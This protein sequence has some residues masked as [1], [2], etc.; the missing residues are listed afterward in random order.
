VHHMI[1]KFNGGETTLTEIRAPVEQELQ[2]HMK[3]HPELLPAD[4]L[5]YE[6]DVLVIGRETALPSG[7][8]DLLAIAE[9]GELLVIEMKRGPENSDF[10]RALAQLVDYGSDLWRLPLD[11]LEHEIVVPYLASK[12][13][14]G[15]AKGAKSLDEAIGLAW[16][17]AGVEPRDVR[18]NLKAT[19]KRGDFTYL[20]AAQTL[21]PNMERAIE[22]LN[23]TSTARFF[24]IEL[25]KFKSEDGGV[26][27]YEGRLRV[28][29]KAATAPSSGIERQEDLIGT[30]AIGQRELV[31]NIFEVADRLRMTVFVGAVGASLKVVVPEL[32]SPVSV[33]WVY[34]DGH[35][36]YGGSRQL[37]LGYSKPQFAKLTSSSERLGAWRA[38]VDGMVGA[39]P[40]EGA[41]VT[42]AILPWG[43]VPANLD[44]TVAALEAL[45]GDDEPSDAPA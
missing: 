15:P 7:R 18:A 4:E 40:I 3:D 10:R 41:A 16:P 22:Y 25:V 31:R 37:T 42:G 44:A 13:C 5:G 43:T 21:T 32:S 11:R 9:T 17:D 34:P 6:L 24:G 20:L 36:G 29:P 1:L 14:R 23:A 28:G 19:L 45:T 30:F 33:G 8:P 26:T 35:T 27:A 38:A 12:H 2:R 39:E